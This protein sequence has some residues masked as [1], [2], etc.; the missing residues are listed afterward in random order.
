MTS[1]APDLSAFAAAESPYL[2]GG[3]A[4]IETEITA[5]DLPVEGHL[6]DDLS[7]VFV[8]T[9][10]NPRLHP[11]GHYHFFDGDGMLHAV[12]FEGGTATYRNRYVRTEGLAEEEAAGRPLWTGILERP[13]FRR[14]GGPYKD[15]GNTD[16][17][18]HA[19][20][21]LALWWLSGKARVIR[22]PELETLGNQD[23]NGKLFR[24]ISAHP[25]V[26]PRTGEMIFFDY[27]PIPPYLT[28]G[29]V[30]AQG[31][32]LHQAPI[33]L[34]GP[35]LQHDTAITERFTLLFDM[36][37]MGDPKQKEPGRMPLRMERNAPARIGLVPRFGTNA[38]VRWFEVAPFFMYHV[39]NAWEEG[40]KVV[41]TGC[42]IADPLMGD[43]RN[44]H[45]AD[46]VPAL[47]NLR[48]APVFHRWT[49]DLATGQA[50]EEVLDDTFTEFP[51]MNDAHLGRPNRYSYHPRLA[52]T[53][54]L[55]FDALIR[56]DLET[57][58]TT[59]HEYPRGWYGGEVSFAARDAA[60]GAEDDGY[61]L[62]FVQ[63]E[64]TGRS[65]LFVLEARD[66][67]APP[68]ARIRIPQRV[69]TGYHTRWVPAAEFLR[70][71][72]L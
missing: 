3:Y 52:R 51:R 2:E 42:R 55:L 6:P 57:G 58:K 13:D 10:S 34:P 32:L 33:E 7:G 5:R 43:P 56:Y 69:P 54:T 29:V 64:A 47:G 26:D 66:V 65:E 37:M 48:L 59:S 15:T 40:E 9:G 25:K 18:F 28:L 36:S 35:R 61:L 62:T 4:P 17:V 46:I 11:A 19:G 44:P 72:P 23:W 63:E 14:Q 67:A 38:D 41:L 49:L 30:S 12:H 21:L 22:L 1:P 60:S 53:Q 16:V 70:Q 27:S 24:S 20:Q 39:I 45:T 31:E 68:V 50:K 71:R 8:R